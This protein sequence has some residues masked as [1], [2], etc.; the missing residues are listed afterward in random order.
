LATARLPLVKL[1]FATRAAQNF[2]RTRADAAPHLIDNAG[3]K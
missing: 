1:D 2:D 3:D